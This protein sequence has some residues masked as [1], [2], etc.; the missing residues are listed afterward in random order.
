MIV[1]DDNLL[2]VGSANL[3]PRSNKLNTELI[4][5]IDSPIMAKEKWHIT[6]KLLN[7]ENF[8]RLSWERYPASFEEDGTPCY[9][10]VWHTIEKGKKRVY[11]TP[12]HS[13]FWRTLGADL[14]SFLPIEGYL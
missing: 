10:P 12:P 4:L 13:G 1:I 8:Y 9:G 2:V 14:L 11:H 6:R 7:E 5:V 3:D